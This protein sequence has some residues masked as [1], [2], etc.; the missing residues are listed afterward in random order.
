MTFFWLA[1]CPDILIIYF[2]Y[3]HAF[4]VRGR[5]TLMLQ[6]STRYLPQCTVAAGPVTLHKNIK[7]GLPSH[8]I[9]N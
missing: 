9:S 6:H 8:I 5:L 7:L 2:R 4:T 1:L 3:A